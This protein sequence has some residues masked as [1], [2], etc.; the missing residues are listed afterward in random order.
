VIEQAATILQPAD[1][2]IR[3]LVVDDDLDI[4]RLLR[5]RLAGRGYQTISATNGEEALAR[6]TESNIDFLMLDVA[7]PGLTGLEVLKRVRGAGSDIPIIMMTA[8]GSERVAIE[9]LRLGANDYLRKPFESTELQAVVDRTV[10]HLLLQ[11][12]VAEL[13]GK[14][15][16]KQRQLELEL[17]RAGEIQAALSPGTSLL[18]PGFELAACCLPARAVGGDFYDW[19]ATAPGEIVLTLGDVMGKGVPAAL[20]MATVRAALRASDYVLSPA[21][22][23]NLAAR[24]LLR[25][26]EASESFLT[27]FHA[28]YTIESRRLIYADAGHGY[29]LVRRADGSVESLLPRGLPLGVLADALCT[30]GETYLAPG[31]TLIIY[32]DGLL[33]ALPGLAEEPFSLVNLL[34][35]LMSARAMVQRLVEVVTRRP[36]LTDDLTV[37]ILACPSEPDG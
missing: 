18:G 23:V 5:V 27:L 19:L 17:E 7:L 14:L 13:Q 37:V 33:E 32:S 2:V 31:D 30:E 35:G 22:A 8:H 4:N 26:F 28:K 1:R 29:V 24:V 16:E 3:G 15:A 21:A 9:A 10:A 25:D 12:Q 11:R 34:K 6:L 20:L 36:A